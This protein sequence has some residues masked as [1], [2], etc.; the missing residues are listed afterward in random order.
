MK[1]LVQGVFFVFAAHLLGQ[2]P[3][4]PAG[5]YI[6]DPAAHVWDDGTLYVYGSL[7]ESTEYY[8][9]WRHHILETDD[10]IN[11]TIHENRFASRGEN[12][13]VPYNNTL[14]FAPDCMVRNG[15]YYLYYCQ[16]DPKN[17]EGVATSDN[18]IGPF[19][20]GQPIDTHG[21]NQIDPNVF[22]DDDGSGYYVWGQFTMKMARLKSNM[23]ELDASTVKDSV[24][25]EFDHF[26][27]EG[28]FM[29]K[30]NGIYYL[31]YADL[32]RANMPT[33]IGYAKSD[34][35]FGPY[36]Y[37]GV[38]V[39]NNRCDPGNWN[40]HGSIAEFNGQWYVFYHRATHNSKMMRKACI[41]PITFHPD[42]SIPEV[43]MTSQGAGAP[44]P[45]TSQIDAERA[46]TLLGN[47]RI[48]L[49]EPNNE[50]LGEIQH[51]DRALFRYIDFGDGV[52]RVMLQVAPGKTTGTIVVKQDMP[53]GPTLAEVRVSKR[54]ATKSRETVTAAVKDV[55]GI[56]PLW[57]MFYS[58]A[59]ETDWNLAVDWLKFE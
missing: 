27:H 45:A 24:L 11:W 33:C 29:T 47:I 17:A 49:S 42:G 25:T 9:S 36:R 41:E 16:P 53:W 55:T 4:V 54:N 52:D 59:P 57:L 1:R 2:N 20:D 7:D 13:A 35:P 40:N 3:I 32:S 12:D 58:D 22:V 26:F 37:G 5:I 50:E 18:P 10:L 8:C 23:I 21:H 48:Q 30:R 51:E 44:L 34:K 38:I 6:A 28:A 39:D 14:L 15:T 46:C 56:H 19:A 31:V 43:L